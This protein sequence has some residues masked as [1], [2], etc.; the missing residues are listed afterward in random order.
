H[1]SDTKVFTMT[2]EILPE[3]TSNKLCGRF[4][5]R[6]KFNELAQYLQDIMMK[7]LPKMVDERIKKILHTQ[8]PLHVEQGIILEREKSQE[9][10]A[11][12]ITDAIQQKRENF[13]SEISSQVND[14]ISN[15]IPLHVDSSVRNL[16]LFALE[17]RTI[18]MM[19]LI[20]R[21]ENSAKRQ[22]TSE[23]G[24][25]VFGESSSGQDYE[26]EPDDDVLPN[27]KVSQ[28]LVDEML[29]TVD[30][31]KLRKVINEM[32]R[33]QC[34]SEDE[35]Q[36]HIDQMQNFLKSDIVWESRKEII[37]PPYQPKPTSVVQCCQRDPKA[38]ALSLVN[39]D[40]LYLK[41]GNTGPEKIAL[42]LHKFPAVRFPDNDIEERTSRWVTKCVKKFNPYARY[43]VE[44][45]KN[46][47]AKIFYIKKQQ[48]PGKPKEEVYSNSK[49]VDDYAEI[50]LFWSLSVFIRN[51]VIW[52]RVH[53]F[54]LGIE[55]YKVFST[56]SEFVYGII[57]K[58]NMK[59]KRVIRHQEVYKFCDATLKRV[60]EG[61]KSYNNNVGY[62]THNLSKDDVKYLQLFAK[63]IEEWLKYH[64]QMYFSFGRHLEELH[65]TWAHFEKKQTRLR[66]YTN[67]S[68][69]NVLSGWRWRH[70]YNVMPS[71]QQRPRR[72]HK[73]P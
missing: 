56:V 19:M 28:E 15:H 32:L 53:D 26:S 69:D 13:R 71:S 8:V 11:K 7:S 16:L 27:E 6:R 61:L 67:I 47:H 36:Y 41:K 18:L 21:G 33:Q 50:G 49:I 5:P 60:L 52:E 30:E 35:H 2:M 4:L 59:E 43:G 39:Q 29:Q 9:E 51:T 20:L 66:T 3:P 46:S 44:H 70:R 34:T 65:V 57:Y 12:M 22:K 64:D 73:I 14:A 48:E 25:F 1:Q 10:V 24:T 42:S 45:C 62:V 23:H 58:N 38:P 63:E 37:V 72:R 17:I 68:Q 54:Q 31:A 40:L 55:K